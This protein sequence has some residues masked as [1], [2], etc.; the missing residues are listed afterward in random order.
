VSDWRFAGY[1]API[2]GFCSRPQ[3]V[4]NVQTGEWH[5]KRCGS[6][7]SKRCE[8]CAEQK[9][10]DVAAVGRSGW[11]DRPTDRAYMITLTAPGADVLPWDQSRCHHSRGVRCSGE[12]G[13]VVEE[14][15]LAVWH[16]D[17]GRRLS[18]VF[19]DVRRALCPGETGRRVADRSVRFEYM[20]TY[21]PQ[22]RGAMHVHM[23]GRVEGA[24]SARRVVAAFKAAAADHGF[25]EQLRVD[26][27]DLSDS[28]NAARAAGYCAKYNTK[29]ADALPDVQRLNRET[30]EIRTGGMRSWS[31]S[32]AWGDT[33]KETRLRRCRW[34][35]LNASTVS[36]AAATLPG[37]A[38][39]GALDPYQDCSASQAHELVDH[40]CDQ[41]L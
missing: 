34:A 1:D 28:G 19:E 22:R 16:D 23:M 6:A 4:V 32:R 26:Q 2:D 20:R 29:S 12:L 31:A 24:A 25:G 35:A 11:V 36:G 27:V 39:G 13:C 33:M 37:D 38:V 17:L 14:H 7:R 30:G 15:A 18:R 21:E 10:H 41:L 9:R 5:L 3:R 40:W 8:S